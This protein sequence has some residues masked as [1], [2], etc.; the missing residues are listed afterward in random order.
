[1]KGKEIKEYPKYS[2]TED[3]EVWSFRRKKPK[4]LKPQSAT[5]NKRY[6]HFR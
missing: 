6:H 5:Q 3:G 1:M 2:I 4:K